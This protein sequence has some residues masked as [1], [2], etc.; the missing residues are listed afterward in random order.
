MT[1]TTRRL[2]ALIL[3]L[4]ML[5]LAACGGNSTKP[6]LR[7]LTLKNYGAAI[8]WNDFDV[9][10]SFVEPAVRA[11][12]PLTDLERERYRQFQVV[13]YEMLNSQVS[14]DG[15][16]LE[17]T[18]EIR[19]VNKNTQYERTVLDHQQWSFDATAKRWWLISGLPK[20]TAQ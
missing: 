20:F 7:E 10:W 18:V 5:C 2:P 11:D 19:V 15:R 16:L 13:S 3:A 8:R 17:Q 9:A 4:L 6:N 1:T 12:R 14:P